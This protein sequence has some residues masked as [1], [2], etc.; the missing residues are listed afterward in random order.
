MTV[1]FHTTHKLHRRSKD[2][3]C[4]RR[5]FVFLD[6]SSWFQRRILFSSKSVVIVG[7]NLTNLQQQY[8][9]ERHWQ[10]S[11]QSLCQSQSSGEQYRVHYPCT[12]FVAI[13]LQILLFDASWNLL[14]TGDIS[15]RSS[16]PPFHLPSLSPRRRRRAACWCNWEHWGTSSSGVSVCLER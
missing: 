10:Q 12:G 1:S 7:I 16:V 6:I 4:N 9:A 8:F 3:R 2:H 15:F 14:G 13:F 11:N 5:W